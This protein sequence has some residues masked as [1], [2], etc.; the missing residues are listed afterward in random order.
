MLRVIFS[1]A[2]LFTLCHG[3][4]VSIAA[5]ERNSDTGDI[6]INGHDLH[7]TVDSSGNNVVVDANDSVITIRGEC[8]ELR[9][10]GS[11]NR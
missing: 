5:T 11:T 3:N 1:M 10:N 7:K 2:V 9:V 4:A 8:N 6:V